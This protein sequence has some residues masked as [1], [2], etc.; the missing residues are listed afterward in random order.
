M[1][2]ILLIVLL[3]VSSCAGIIRA[4]DYD[5]GTVATV[6]YLRDIE[7]CTEKAAGYKKLTGWANSYMAIC[8]EGRGYGL[9]K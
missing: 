4:E 6:V 9:K 1:R 7:E 3:S 5:R 8:M 2:N